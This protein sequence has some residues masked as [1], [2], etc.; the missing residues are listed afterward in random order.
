VQFLD[1]RLASAFLSLAL[2]A[3]GRSKVASGDAGAEAAVEAP[4]GETKGS[5]TPGT[6]TL[7]AGWHA[8]DVS[9]AL[10]VT[11]VGAQLT[12]WQDFPT[13]HVFTLIWDPAA[14]RVMAGTDG[15]V[16]ASAAATTDGRTFR[17]TEPLAVRVPFAGSC[18][19]TAEI[20]YDEI[21]FFAESGVLHGTG[22]GHATYLNGDQV[23]MANATATLVGVPDVT[24]PSLDVPAVVEDPLAPVFL[25]ASEPLPASA[26][27]SLVGAP[28]GDVI[29]LEPSVLA[30]PDHVTWGFAKPGVMLRYGETYTLVTD[31]LADF[32]GNKSA[33]A[34]PTTF[35]TRAAPPLIPEDGFESVT[36][37]TLGGAG[38]LKGDPLTPIAGTTSL[39]LNTGFG[40]GF[41]F[42]PYRLGPAL[43][44]RLTVAPGDTVV[45]FA[46][47][48]VATYPLQSAAFY[49][50]IR[51][52]SV[53]QAVGSRMNVEATDFTKVTLP[54]D[55]DV[56]ISPVTTIEL[57]L[58]AGATGELTFEIDGDT[59]GCGVP[60]PPTALIL[61]DLR[62][63]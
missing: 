31:N 43:A 25:K 9:G 52:G 32:A 28:S 36:T 40:G 1:R 4:G 47:R 14:G 21:T 44:V 24:A 57:P 17:T 19:G 35:T 8:F 33:A 3:C 46:S 58:P 23:W 12:G 13:D 54:T 15:L 41:G 18:G 59:F 26:S 49:G 45:R 55:G 62:V 37:P 53:G 63:E 20:A 27:V 7:L 5:D 11:P 30:G 10:T 16:T 6:D 42:L 48:L 56:Y 2:V 38:V 50:E 39:I 61:D 22:D 29:Q 51:L 60:P 34:Q